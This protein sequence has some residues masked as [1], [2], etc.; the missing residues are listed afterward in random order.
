[1]DEFLEGTDEGVSPAERRK[2]NAAYLKKT[3]AK[4]RQASK[5]G[6]DPAQVNQRRNT[7][8]LKKR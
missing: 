2:R 4:Y 7:P 3:M 8:T 6:M 5:M 1:I